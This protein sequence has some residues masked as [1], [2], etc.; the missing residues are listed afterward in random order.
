MIVLCL[1]A[2]NHGTEIQEKGQLYCTEKDREKLIQI[3]KSKTEEFRKVQRAKIFL[4]YMDNI[5]VTQI[6]KNAGLAV[7]LFIPL[8]IRLLLLDQ[9]PDWKTCPVEVRTLKLVMMIKPGLSI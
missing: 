4:Q 2:K 5:P 7:N 1:C 8:L 6:A 9:L 3:P